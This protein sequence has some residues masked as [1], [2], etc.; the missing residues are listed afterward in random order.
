MIETSRYA[1]PLAEQLSERIR[2]HGPLTFH[3]WMRTA[4]YDPTD[5]YYCRAGSKKWGREGDYRT[6]AERSSLFAATF[7][8]YFVRLFENLDKPR[9]WTIVEAGAGEGR[10]AHGLLE[11]LQNYFPHVYSVTRYIISEVSSN[12]VLRKRLE[13]FTDRVQFRR[14]E[15][16]EAVAGIV[17]SNELLDAFP[18]H[19]VT[20]DRSQLREFYIDV[21]ANGEFEWTLGAVSNSRLSEYF[22]ESGIELGEGQIAEV[23]L[24]IESWLTK[25]ATRLS[26]GYLVTVDYGAEAAELYGA[27]TRRHGTL[28]GFS[29]HQHVDDVLGRPG[30]QDLTT[31]I[32]WTFVKRVGKE[33]GFEV[34]EFQRQDKFLLANGLLD[35][36]EVEMQSINDEAEKLRLSTTAQEM[37]LPTGM[38]SSFQVLVQKKTS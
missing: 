33:L 7:A 25:V 27:P 3:D 1:S 29:R 18:V 15:E 19:R 17:F 38:A 20:I 28:R 13:A 4:L 10:F 22:K 5:G 23:N 32:D 16:L 36:L 8:R 11:T 35:Q 26:N 2:R 6:S 30:E 31:T 34:I 21:T 12:T 14:L 24:E 37:I 9:E